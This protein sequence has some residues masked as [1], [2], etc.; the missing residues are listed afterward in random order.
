MS[1][2]TRLPAFPQLHV[3]AGPMH[4]TI[5]CSELFMIVATVFGLVLATPSGS[6]STLV[7]GLEDSMLLA[8]CLAGA[9][10]AAACSVFMWPAKTQRESLGIF[11]GNS[12]FGG[13]FGPAV[14]NL[15]C[16]YLQLP[17]TMANALAI[18]G[19]LSFV[20]S[21]AVR[22]TGPVLL[23]RLVKWSE[24]ATVGGMFLDAI[25]RMLNLKRV[26]PGSPGDPPSNQ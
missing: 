13:V 16:P 22:A 8:W 25:L 1:Q 17:V 15:A 2:A 26:Q 6:S 21:T 24:T 11:M 23:S 14:V 4:S 9:V 7:G 20:V 5:F 3:E 19:A 12:L 18:A 10:G